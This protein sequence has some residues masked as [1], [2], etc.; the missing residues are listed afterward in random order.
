[1]EPSVNDIR[2]R[3]NIPKK[4]KFLGWAIHDHMRDEFLSVA[5]IKGA[6]TQLIWAMTP[7]CAKTFKVFA[8][9]VAYADSHDLRG[10]CAL[11]ALFDSGRQ[12]LV[13]SD[14]PDPVNAAVSILRTQ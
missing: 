4:A 10:R 13:A 14:R 3:L 9:A 5:N 6:T 1:M 8:D 7:E 11:V 12:I 2:A